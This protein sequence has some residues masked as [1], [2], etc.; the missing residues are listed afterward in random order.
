MS[1]RW[2]HGNQ[3]WPEPR[4]PPAADAEGGQHLRERA[5]VAVE[6]DADAGDAE[7]HAELGDPAAPRAPTRR[8]GRG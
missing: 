8:T 6:H 1:S 2:I 3:C 5:A 7:A 4:R